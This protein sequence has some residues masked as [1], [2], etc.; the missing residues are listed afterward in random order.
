MSV[1]I[2]A[3]PLAAVKSNFV[4]QHFP[5]RT[6]IDLGNFQKSINA[7]PMDIFKSYQ[8]CRDA[9]QQAL[10]ENK[11]VVLKHPLLKRQ[12]RPMYIDAIREFTD[13]D[14]EM[15]FLFPSL[16]KWKDTRLQEY[17]QLM[18]DIADIPTVDEGY[19]KVHVIRDADTSSDTVAHNKGE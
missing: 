9:L 14:I 10:R 15:Y 3:G 18:C 4:E 6:I 19:S 8:A 1:I 12:R 2:V 13:E 7:T 11:K 17:V 5:D 16:E